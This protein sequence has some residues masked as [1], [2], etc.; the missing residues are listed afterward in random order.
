MDKFTKVK[1]LNHLR[2]VLLLVILIA[3]VASG[4]KRSRPDISVVS[5]RYYPNQ[6]TLTIN[7]S[8]E[9]LRAEEKMALLD[10]PTLSGKIDFTAYSSTGL[11][12]GA[13]VILILQKP[14]EGQIYLPVPDDTTVIYIQEE[15]GW[16]MIPDNV[17]TLDDVHLRLETRNEGKIYGTEAILELPG[18][19]GSE[20]LLGGVG[21]AEE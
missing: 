2:L 11:G 3:V 19:G 17:P 7:D 6:G 16:K 15:T 8:A 9:L 14:V 1:S 13:R 18:P 10:D 12:F 5:G 4:C 21:W 20:E